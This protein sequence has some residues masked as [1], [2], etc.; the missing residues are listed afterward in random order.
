LI[1]NPASASITLRQPVSSHKG[2]NTKATLIRRRA[3]RRLAVG[4]GVHDDLFLGEAR[5]RAQPPLQLPAL[6]PIFKRPRVAMTR[7]RTAP[8]SRRFSTICR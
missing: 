7:G 2:S 6:A 1:R 3:H 5:T 4:D 8:S